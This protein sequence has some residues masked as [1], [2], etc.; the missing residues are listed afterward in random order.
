[1]NRKK[2]TI[3]LL[4]CLLLTLTSCQRERTIRFRE[5]L[6]A[7]A[8]EITNIIQRQIKLPATIELSLFNDKMSA[9]MNIEYGTSETEW[10]TDYCIL[11]PNDV[12]GTE[13]AVFIYDNSRGL[14]EAKKLVKKRTEL[15]RSV[16]EKNNKK[17]LENLDNSIILQFD[18]AIVFIMTENDNDRI[19][20]II[21]SFAATKIPV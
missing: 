6:N 10:I 8:A 19:K 12:T 7:S 18:N 11:V 15:I 17:R 5:A 2:I 14:S 16:S 21:E 20:S 9:A 13:I 4:L 1:M 3:F